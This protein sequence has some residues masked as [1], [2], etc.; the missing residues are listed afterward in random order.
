MKYRAIIS[1]CSSTVGGVGVGDGV[2]GGVV[3]TEA[4][5]KISS[6][7]VGTGVAKI[8]SMIV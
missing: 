3:V 1:C 7:S 2:V 6:G 4:S 5:T 8:S